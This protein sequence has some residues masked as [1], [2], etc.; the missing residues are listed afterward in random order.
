MGTLFSDLKGLVFDVP[1]SSEFYRL[2]NV[3]DGGSSRSS[4]DDDKRISVVNPSDFMPEYHHLSLSKSK[5]R[6]GTCSRPDGFPFTIPDCSHIKSYICVFCDRSSTNRISMSIPI[7]ASIVNGGYY[8]HSWLDKKVKIKQNSGISHQ[9]RV[10]YL[11]EHDKKLYVRCLWVSAP[12]A[13][14]SAS[15]YFDR[16]SHQYKDVNID[17]VAYLNPQLPK[18]AAVQIIPSTSGIGEI[19]VIQLSLFEACQHL[20]SRYTDY[21]NLK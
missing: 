2:G 11:F 9:A 17:E 7:F 13:E 16:T 5:G 6:C 3:N 4:N 19:T 12:N 14:P 1:P 8:M 10:S 21:Y 18:L 20:I 15:P